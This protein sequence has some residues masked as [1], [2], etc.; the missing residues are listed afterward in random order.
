MQTLKLCV[1]IFILTF[2]LLGVSSA[3]GGSAD[4]KKRPTRFGV[5]FSNMAE[6]VV[7]KEGRRGEGK[8]LLFIRLNEKGM[9][10]IEGLTKSH[11]G[12]IVEFVFDGVVLSR[13]LIRDP[14]PVRG[15]VSYPWSSEDAAEEMAK[16]LRNK[17]LKVPCG[18]INP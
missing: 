6:V 3:L 15:M 12:K 17:F 10:Q 18:Q 2:S 5:C 9:H 13:D 8:T 16:L 14:I 1:G 7:V 11:Q 4:P